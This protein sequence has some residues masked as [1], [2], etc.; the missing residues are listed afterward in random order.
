M[1]TKS[2]QNLARKKERSIKMNNQQREEPRNRFIMCRR[3]GEQV[4]WNKRKLCGICRNTT[5]EPFD[6]GVNN[7]DGEQESFDRMEYEHRLNNR[8]NIINNNLCNPG[9]IDEVK[10]RDSIRIIAVNPHGFGPDCTEKIEMLCQK[11]QEMEIDM[12]LM[13]S[14]D[15][16][17]TSNRIE[18]LTNKFRRINKA[19]EIIATDSGEKTESEIGWLPGGTITIVIGRLVGM[20]DKNNITKEKKGT[21]CAFTLEENGRKIRIVNLYRIPDNTNK[22]MMT[23]K[24][25]YDRAGKQT[26]SAKFYREAILL[27][28]ANEISNSKTK[29]INDYIV[30]GDFNQDVTKERIVRFANENELEEIH[31]EYN[32]RDD[33][34]RDATHARGQCQI[35]AI[36][37]SKGV[38]NC[39][40]G[41]RIMDFNEVIITDHR[42]F[43]IDI[44]INKY[45]KKR[46][47]RY[48]EIQ[49]RTLNPNN[50]VHRTKFKKKLDQYL[51][52]SKLFET[53]M[54]KCT[55]GISPK[56]LNIID[57]EITY[58]L[59]V[60]RKGVE[61]I[62]TGIP[63][64]QE[65]QTKLSTM[66]YLSAVIRKMKGK[67]VD[68]KALERRKEYANIDVNGK[69]INEIEEMYKQAIAT[70]NSFKEES[71]RSREDKLMEL[72]PYDIADDNENNAK[73]RRK[74]LK[75]VMQAQN[76]QRTFTM[77]TKYVG[78][79]QKQTLKRLNIPMQDGQNYKQVS[80]RRTIENEIINYNKKHFKQAFT[81]KAYIDKI[82]ENLRHDEIRDKVLKGELQKSECD[83]EEVYEFLRLLKKDLYESNFRTN[84]EISE[85]EWKKVVNKAKRKS[86][87]SVFSNRT[88]S[89]YKCALDSDEMTKILIKFCNTVM[90]QEIY[91]KRWLKVLDIILEKGKGPFLGKLRTIQLIEADLQLMMR[92]FIGARNDENIAQ[93][94]RLSTFNYGSR[95][96]YSI[97]TAILEKR[98]MYDNSIRDGKTTIHTISDLKACYD[99]QLPN[100]GCMVQ[101][102]VGVQRNFAKLMQ[103]VLPIMKHHVATDFGISSTS[104]GDKM[105]QLGGT[106]QGNSASGAICRD[107]SCVIFKHLEDLKL[108]AQIRIASEDRYIQRV[109]IAFV[110]DTDFYA[111]GPQ[112]QMNMQQ[113]MTNYTK[114]YEATGG[115]IQESKVMCYCWNW[116]YVKGK[117][118]I[119]Q[120]KADIVVH[121]ERIESVPINEATRTLGVHIN[122][123]LSWKSQF[124][125]MRTKLNKSITNFMRMDVNPY[126]AAVYY[127]T[128]MIRT[129]YFG[130]GIMTLDPKEELELKRIYERPLLTKLGFSVTFPRYAMYARKSALGLGLMTPRTMI[131]MLKLKLYIGAK[132]LKKNAGDAVQA[133]IDMVYEEAGR[134]F[135]IGENPKRRYWKETWVDEV[136]DLLWR[137]EMQLKS[138][139]KRKFFDSKNKTIMEYA[140]EYVNEKRCTDE[141]LYQLN[142]IRMKKEV[143]YPFELVGFEGTQRTSCYHN[144]NEKGPVKWDINKTINAKVTTM[145]KEIW[146]T[147]LRWLKEQRIKTILDF[148]GLKWKWRRSSD[149]RTIRIEEDSQIKYYRRV[150]KTNKYEQIE[151]EDNSGDFSFGIIGDKNRRNLV[152]VHGE[153]EI[154]DYENNSDE[155]DEN[156]FTGVLKQAIIER[157]AVA[158][159][160]ASMLGNMMATHWIITTLAQDA[161]IE[162]GI[163]SKKWAEGLVPVGEAIGLLD[164]IKQIVQKTKSIPSGEIVVYSDNKY[165][166]KK[167][168]NPAHKESDVTGD[169]GATIT[170]IKEEINKATIS[171]LIEYANNKPRPGKTF[172][173][174]P[175]A[176]LIKKCDEISKQKRLLLQNNIVTRPILHCG[177][178][179][180]YKE[181]AMMDKNINVLMREIDGQDHEMQGI[182][183]IFLEKWEWV[184]R[185]A[186][187]CFAAGV[188]AGTMKCAYGYNHHGKR[189]AKINNDVCRNKCPRCNAIEDW[190]HIILCKGVES[191]KN[192]YIEELKVLTT[193]EKINDEER[194]MVNLIINDIESYLL[195]DGNEYNTT[196][197]LIGMKMIFRGW[198]VKNWSNVNQQTSFNMKKINK[199]IVK[200]S[201]QFYSKCWKHRN[202]IMHSP[203]I[204]RK[205]MEEWY[206][207]LRELIVRGN[208]PEMHK[209]LKTYEINVDQCSTSYIRKWNIDASEMYKK[210]STERLSDIR[211]FFRRQ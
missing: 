201:V 147:F 6:A 64:N 82:Y 11:V 162:G 167:I 114:L 63:Y 119:K 59:N 168:N 70:W 34:Y 121:N 128:Y 192:E 195:D 175:G 142:Y 186:R 72:Y 131:E 205:Y 136:N 197:H 189:N 145:Q 35:D 52:D 150:E 113:I 66:K 130:C 76:R 37:A 31:Q 203:E 178:E 89:I 23:S 210:A 4:S 117:Q 10:H 50:R 151:D 3:C 7:W 139:E 75:T 157:K 108:G 171:I 80:D 68:E 122:P 177:V 2:N 97:D 141:V 148:K 69:E 190:E 98:L 182:K 40:K 198:V 62:Y 20:I 199:I 123:A 9:Y 33:I 48:D 161:E 44:N 181:D 38:L 65:K 57:D 5:I 134:N 17:W 104:Y 45:F 149:K 102:S 209:Y 58:A 116:N 49:S 51:K 30:A 105:N 36:F 96:Y 206:C 93:D 204:Y 155:S 202:E 129:V 46:Y 173:Q 54:T 16:R 28:I 94:K 29:G 15:R 14:P 207:N 146:Q 95:R 169:A 191:L 133:Q 137:R 112:F 101:E 78:K 88:Y 84:E 120:M 110:D 21:W 152:T 81:S 103:T 124:E 126:Q 158:A 164:L 100:I 90:Q 12:I 24:A 106:G 25:Q 47:S 77:L 61:G 185:E 179:T 163:E 143:V 153:I 85:N 79:G 156:E 184:D 193:K 19:V 118:Q 166:I 107:T 132:R 115:K 127:N 32:F 211:M 41:S 86:A 160:D 43:M 42:G 196:Q 188:G 138:P 194:L 22:G 183:N 187:N 73:R 1:K 176:V 135:E 111:N 144:I 67:R 125:V 180:P 170:A 74:A 165:I 159:T 87:S 91:P 56:E 26:K 99:R 53:V 200:I 8:I 13:S 71:K 154:R 174:Q 208:K 60:A 172:S 140:I 83:Y 27:E 39:I 92:I 18:Q 55:N 109:A